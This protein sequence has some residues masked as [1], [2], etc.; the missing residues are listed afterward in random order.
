MIQF[1]KRMVAPTIVGTWM[2]SSEYHL[3]NRL[4]RLGAEIP[5]KRLSKSWMNS[6]LQ[7]H[8]QVD[9]AIQVVKNCGLIPHGDPPK[10]WDGIS[11]LDEI[12]QR[13]DNQANI[14]EVGATLYSTLLVWLFQYGY[15]NL[16][17]IDLIFDKPLRRGP[18]R[19]EPGDLTH[20]RF[21]DE[22]FDAI[23]SMSVIEHGVD[24]HA[25]FKEMFR[26]LKPNGV[27]LTSTDYWKDVVDTK[28]QKA[29][30]VPITIFNEDDI[31]NMLDCAHGYGFQSC[32]NINLNCEERVVHW[33]QFDLRY[34]FV[35]FALQKA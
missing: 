21:H 19:Y 25:Y 11:M 31:R 4:M 24:I 28:C 15:R 27:L 12:L 6:T 14:L 33:K 13:T 26:L 5:A 7:V 10:N 17:G 35:C 20:S 16:M 8:S 2:Q 9:E 30:G 22:S 34:T 3:K 18:I 32:G 29:F 23:V 1:M